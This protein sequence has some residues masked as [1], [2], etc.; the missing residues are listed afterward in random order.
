MDKL[1]LLSGNSGAKAAGTP[2]SSRFMRKLS[3]RPPDPICI[4][5]CRYASAR[6]PSASAFRGFLPMKTNR[7]PQEGLQGVSLVVR[8]MTRPLFTLRRDSPRTANV[9]VY[10]GLY[11][12]PSCAVAL[13]SRLT[14]R[15]QLLSR[16]GCTTSLMT[17]TMRP[18]RR[19]AHR[20]YQ[21]TPTLAD[22]W[23][24]LTEGL[25]SLA[26]QIRACSGTHAEAA[27]LAWFAYEQDHEP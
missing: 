22:R 26:A 8:L 2:G 6:R 21:G 20:C 13:H 14:T 4:R 24:R 15:K 16:S 18:Q 7:A 1:G 27:S 19:T 3:P 9:D 12:R 17:L 5:T 10:A 23:W 25:T 11:S